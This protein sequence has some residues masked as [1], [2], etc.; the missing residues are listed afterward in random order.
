MGGDPSN[1]GWFW[2]GRLIPFTDYEAIL[3]NCFSLSPVY[4]FKKRRFCA[5]GKPSAFAK[6][7]IGRKKT[8]I[9]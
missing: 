4:V 5:V 6:L 2:N 8:K 7:E 9:F 1:E 3:D